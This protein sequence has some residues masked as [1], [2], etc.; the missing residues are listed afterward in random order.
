MVARDPELACDS[1]THREIS[2]EI[3]VTNREE[4]EHGL[5]VRSSY[6]LI[7]IRDPDKGPVRYKKPC[8]LVA[9]LEI[10]FHDAEPTAGFTPPSNIQMMT[11]ANAQQI[12]DFIVQQTG[13][14]DTL[15]VHC[16]QGM[17]RSPAVALA[18]AEYFELNTS[19]IEK[20]YQPNQYVYGLVIDAL[21]EVTPAVGTMN[22]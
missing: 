21:R 3:I 22:D 8:G 20:S 1:A 2:M 14:V 19:W 6:L 10:A 12:A 18:I 5:V 16:E 4:I 9:A 15:V 13:H 17:S 11:H 7:S